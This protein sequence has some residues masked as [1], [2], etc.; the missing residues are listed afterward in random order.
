MTLIPGDGIG[1]EL[2]HHVRELF[3]CEFTHPAHR[4]THTHTE[5]QTHTLLQTHTH[6]HSHTVGMKS[7]TDSYTD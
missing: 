1:P 3:R 7:V 6:T 4:H 5:T 2:A